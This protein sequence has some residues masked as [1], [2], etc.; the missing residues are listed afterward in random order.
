M[1]WIL[2]SSTETLPCS[3][4]SWQMLNIWATGNPIL[5]MGSHNNF[6]GISGDCDIR[7]AL[8]LTSVYSSWIVLRQKFQAEDTGSS[9]SCLTLRK[10]KFI[11]TK[12]WALNAAFPFGNS[13]HR[14]VFYLLGERER[15]R[16]RGVV[17]VRDTTIGGG[18]WKHYF[19]L[20]E[21]SQTLPASPSGKG[22]A[23]I[24]KLLKLEGLY[25]L[26]FI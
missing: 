12:M 11:R 16:E 15:E 19:F 1:G 18:E 2:E 25:Y 24:L 3:D 13:V 6:Q 26:S 21:G 8:T 5:K 10:Y 9:L 4:Y 22:E 14:P 17:V 7:Q 20:I 23:L